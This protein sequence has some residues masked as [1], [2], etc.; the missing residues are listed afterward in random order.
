MKKNWSWSKK[1]YHCTIQASNVLYTS[2]WS[3]IYS[4]CQQNAFD[5]FTVTPFVSKTHHLPARL[6]TITTSR[7][8]LF[9][10]KAVLLMKNYSSRCYNSDEIRV[11]YL[12]K[13]RSTQ[14]HVNCSTR[15]AHKSIFTVREVQLRPFAGTPLNLS[16]QP[17]ILF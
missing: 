10:R 13:T 14:I 4:T 16:Y 17:R 8:A 9:R 15:S 12:F 11:V 3:T 7:I 6:R 1:S 5:I 2:I